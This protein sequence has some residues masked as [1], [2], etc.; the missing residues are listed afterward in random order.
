MLRNRQQLLVA[1]KVLDLKTSECELKQ[2]SE[3]VPRR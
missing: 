1:G 2:L 3:E